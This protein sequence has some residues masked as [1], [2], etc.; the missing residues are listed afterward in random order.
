MAHKSIADIKLLVDEFIPNR[1]QST[2]KNKLIDEI[3]RTIRHYTPDVKVWSTQT[4]ANQQVYDLPTHIRV[5]DIIRFEFSP[6]TYNSTTVVS[7]TLYWDFYKFVGYEDRNKSNIFYRGTTKA[8]ESERVGINP[9]PE[10]VNYIRVMYWDYPQT[11]DSTD[12]IENDYMTDYIQYK[13]MA[14]IARIGNHPRIDLSNNY[15]IEA[16]AALRKLK[17]DREKIKLA[18]SPKRISYKDWWD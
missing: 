7:S 3:A 16:E 10:D 2:T 18:L 12:V 1:V 4:V 5:D 14:R 9:I 6:T 8:S 17:Q 13:L 15:E 11:S